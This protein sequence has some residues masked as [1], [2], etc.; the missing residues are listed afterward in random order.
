MTWR[1]IIG[2]EVNG[3]AEPT[4]FPIAAER[5][6]PHRPPM[7]VVEAL[8]TFDGKGGT[9]SAR[10]VRE[11]PLLEEGGALA[12]VGLLELLA[13]AYAAVQGYADSLSGEPVRRGF[14]VGVRKITFLR[15]AHLGDA[16]IIRVRVVA[17]LENFAIVEGTV[18][19]GEKPLAEGT[20]KVWIVPTEGSDQ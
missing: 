7:Q 4:I 1:P 13:Q 14:L 16:L 19:K 2:S 20:F 10:V 6:I 8:Q 17:R 5:L 18:L 12:E 9:V 15:Q 11:N 3:M